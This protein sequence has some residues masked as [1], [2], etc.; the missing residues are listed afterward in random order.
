MPRPFPGPTARPGSWPTTCLTLPPT[1]VT[2]TS[3]RRPEPPGRTCRPGR[4]RKRPRGSGRSPERPTVATHSRAARQDGRV[5][6]RVE[7]ATIPWLEALVGGNGEFTARFGLPVETGWAVYPEAVVHALDAVRMGANPAWGTHLFFDDDADGALVGFGGWKARRVR[8]G[9]AGLRGG[10]VAAGPR[11]RHR[12]GPHADRPGGRGG[13]HDRAGPHPPGGVGV[14]H[15]AAPHRV[16][17]G[18]R[19]H[20]GRRSRCGA[21]NAPPAT[22][23]PAEPGASPTEQAGEPPS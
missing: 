1:P 4:R 20:R 13:G 15:R 10:A 16:H 6:V 17:A 22:R 7:P 21:G 12:G 8:R 14:D 2:V 5:P 9:R 18:G 3:P 19:R 23:P 11:D